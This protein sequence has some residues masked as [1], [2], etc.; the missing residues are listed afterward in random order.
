M[1]SANS[2]ED[3]GFSEPLRGAFQSW[4]S[5]SRFKSVVSRARYD[6]HHQVLQ[7]L[8][9]A[10]PMT[11]GFEYG[12]R[13]HFSI[14]AGGAL[15]YHRRREKG[16]LV[17]VPEDRIFDVI[18]EEHNAV[19]HQGI[20]KTWGEVTARY[21]GIPKRAVSWLV[22]HCSV[23]QQYEKGGGAQAYTPIVSKGVMERVQ[24]DLIDMRSTPD[25]QY[26]WILHI[27]DHFSRYCM[28]YPMHDRNGDEVVRHFLEWIALLGPPSILQTDNGSEFVNGAI[29]TVA[30]QSR[31]QI[32]RA[33]LRRPQTQGLVERANAHVRHMVAK[34]CRRFGRRDWAS[35]LPTIALACNTSV[36]ETTGRSPY[37]VVFGRRPHMQRVRTG[38]GCSEEASRPVVSAE[39]EVMLD[40]VH[41]RNELDRERKRARA[42][43]GRHPPGTY[44]SVA[45]TGVQRTG[46][47]AYRIPGVLLR[48]EAPLGYRVCTAWGVL[49][50]PVA[51]RHVRV[52]PEDSTI[53][54]AALE[55][56]QQPDQAR[57]VSVAE[58][59]QRSSR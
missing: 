3:T 16:A 7:G 49:Q 37:E 28:L 41:R 32:I 2:G 21:H 18:A 43:D 22:K 12:T 56:F 26:R 24:M 57:T 38:D 40:E 5:S 45:L 23:C 35:S 54:Q 51:S 39:Y 15:L 8:P 52:L 50:R 6:A 53:P 20:T 25:G 9:L 19:H 42:P 33:Q 46:L 27:K 55:C 10:E 29:E 48:F 13:R 36:H 4:L 1:A 17:V 31:I 47:D 14:D 34:W 44:V 58:C 59:L 30:R 11:P